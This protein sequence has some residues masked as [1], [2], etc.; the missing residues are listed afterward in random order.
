MWDRRKIAKDVLAATA[1]VLV[2]WA[3]RWLLATFI[4]VHFALITFFPAMFL[5]AVW[6]GLR[7]TAI[8]VALS[9]VILGYA[10]WQPESAYVRSDYEYQI[11]FG[12]FVAI[13]LAAGWLGNKALAAQR[14]AK[15]ATETAV[16][17]GKQLRINV[18]NRKRAEE[19][20]TFLANAS[21]SLAALV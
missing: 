6:V 15:S 9:S 3:A 4:G 19:A 8:G 17:E 7:A 2:A 12:L 1:V 18:A 14:L 16:N 11:A 21:T 5:L 10:L 20:L 13:S